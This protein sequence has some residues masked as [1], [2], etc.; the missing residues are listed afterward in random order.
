MRAFLGWL[1]GEKRHCS[2]AAI[3]TLEE[4]DA[5]RPNRERDNLVRERR[6]SCLAAIEVR[7]I[8][9]AL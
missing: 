1:R 8:C 2:V 6:R 3:P 7:P 9:S 5:R 4:E